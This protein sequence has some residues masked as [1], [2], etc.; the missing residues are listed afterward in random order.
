MAVREG[1]WIMVNS[2][3]KILIKFNHDIYILKESSVSKWKQLDLLEV[4]HYK[5]NKKPSVFNSFMNEEG[6]FDASMCILCDMS[7][8]FNIQGTPEWFLPHW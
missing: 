4:T 8:T 3:L 5:E 1:V 7:I 6:T 2:E